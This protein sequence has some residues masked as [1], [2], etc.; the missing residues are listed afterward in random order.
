MFVSRLAQ[1]DEPRILGKAAGVKVERN[2]VPRQTALTCRAFSIETGCPPPELLVTVSITSGMRSRPTRS[3][4]ALQRGHIHVALERMLQAQA[5]L[6]SGITR[7]TASA[8]V[9]STLA[10][11]VSKCV[12]LGTTSPF[13]QAHAKQD[14]LGGAA[15]VRGNHVLVA[16]DILD[17]SS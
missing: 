8:P 3:I 13:L 14:A 9:N 11:V 2:A 10:R 4:R 6:P 16:E 5:G 17:G 7:S 15:L 12:L 1:L